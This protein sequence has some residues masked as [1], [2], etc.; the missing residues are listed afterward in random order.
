MCVTKLDVLDGMDTMRICTG[1]KLDGEICDILPVGSESLAE[2]EP[3]YEEHAGLERQHGRREDLRA[4]PP[5]PSP[6]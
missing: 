5:T 6:T 4:C 3:I 1:Y 2:C